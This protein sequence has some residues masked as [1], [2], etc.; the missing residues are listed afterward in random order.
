MSVQPGKEALGHFPVDGP[1]FYSVRDHHHR[2]CDTIGA[3]IRFIK[4]WPEDGD[5]GFLGDW[6]MNAY[7]SQLTKNRR[8]L[9]VWFASILVPELCLL[10]QVFNSL[11]FLEGDVFS[12]TDNV[13]V[14][15]A[16]GC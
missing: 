4:N 12:G 11:E 5:L 7:G 10:V 9:A 14:F 1:S 2:C 13:C 16:A 6:N 3:G 15:G 8:E